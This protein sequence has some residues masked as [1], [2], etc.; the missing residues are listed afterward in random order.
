MGKNSMPNEGI[1]LASL[2]KLF[3]TGESG[4]DTDVHDTEKINDPW[5]SD[6]PMTVGEDHAINPTRSSRSNNRSLYKGSVQLHRRITNSTSLH[7]ALTERQS[8][9]DEGR[10]LTIP[11]RSV[12][13][14]LAK[15][16]MASISLRDSQSLGIFYL[17]AAVSDF[18]VPLAERSPHK[19]Q[20]RDI[21][22]DNSDS[23]LTKESGNSCLSLKLWPVP[24][25]MGL[26]RYKWA[27]DAFICS[28][29]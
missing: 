24:K 29:Y 26:L 27:P 8:A 15:L 22:E 23:V 3:T 5:L 19:I 6:P 2:G 14:Y 12:E 4:E 13:E 10:I 1:S 9:I 20:S 16:Q 7:T 18:Y 17:A 11:F 21:P 28:K 25:V